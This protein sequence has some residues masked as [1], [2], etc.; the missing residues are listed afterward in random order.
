MGA[1]GTAPTSRGLEEP[2]G[3]RGDRTGRA[4]VRVPRPVRLHRVHGNARRARGDRHHQPLP[5]VGAAISRCAGGARREVARRR[6]DDHRRRGR[7]DDRH[8]GRADRPV[9]RSATGAPRRRRPRPGPDRRRRRLH[10]SAREPRVPPLP[11]RPARRAARGRLPRIGAAA[12]DHRARHPQCHGAGHRPA[13]RVSSSSV[14]SPTSSCRGSPCPCR[15]RRIRRTTARSRLRATPRSRRSGSSASTRARWADERL[16]DFEGL[17]RVGARRA[18]AAR[19]QTL[20]QHRVAAVDAADVA[21]P[22][23]PAGDPVVRSTTPS[24]ARCAL[25]LRLTVFFECSTS[26]A[27]RA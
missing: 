16:G 12:L 1:I 27:L 2:R 15:S 22:V 9:R 17:D 11:D 18:P 20:V 25:D 5:L 6:R 19:E 23:R 4:G 3:R 10:R 8:C 14:W 13:P 24:H 7:P 21:D 26:W